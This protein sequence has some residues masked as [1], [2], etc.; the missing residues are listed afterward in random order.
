MKMTSHFPAFSP[1]SSSFSKST[2]FCSNFS[3]PDV[4]WSRGVTLRPYSPTRVKCGDD[5][6]SFSKY[7]P[8][9]PVAPMRSA[10]WPTWS[11]ILVDTALERNFYSPAILNGPLW[12]IGWWWLSKGLAFGGKCPTCCDIHVSDYL[13]IRDEIKTRSMYYFLGILI[14]S[15]SLWLADNDSENG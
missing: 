3:C 15:L 2:V 11:K 12:A 6:S 8:V 9:A 1:A 5:S 4:I 7:F 13:W 14:S 10:D